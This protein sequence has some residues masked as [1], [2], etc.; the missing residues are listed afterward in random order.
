M[1]KTF[2]LLFTLLLCTCAFTGFAQND[3]IE[4]NGKISTQTRQVGTF[5]V[6]SIS[7]GFEV[8][9]TQG[10]TESLKLEADENVLPRIT[11][12][13]ENGVLRI[14]SKNIRNAKRLKAYVTVR[15]LNSLR[16]AGGIK[17]RGTNTL[18]GG[19]LKFEFAGGIDVQMALQVKEL[20]ADVAG[21]TNIT[22]TGQAQTVRLDLAGASTFKAADL[23]TEVFTLDAA[24][25]SHAEVHVTKQLN[26][27]A[28]GIVSVDY[29]GSP[30][31]NH[32]GMGK[33]RPM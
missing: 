12:E 33:V 24:G 27:D 25:A 28:A 9:L 2:A 8:V 32:S 15:D 21:G 10:N 14:S 23:K 31:I 7:G 13:V 17:L 11:S 16:L 3:K 4:G 29:K 5:T 26:V 19:T 22:L 1:K 6:L 20:V 30:K 18:T